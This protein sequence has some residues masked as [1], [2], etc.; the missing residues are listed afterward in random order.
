MNVIITLPSKLIQLIKEG[1]KR[2]EL[3]KKWPKY[4]N[5]QTDNIYICEKGTKY[6]VGYMT[7]EQIIR[8]NNKY[9]ILTDW[10]K[11]IAVSPEWIADYIK[12]AH[13]LVGLFIGE[14]KSFD[15]PLSLDEYFHV[16]KAP[17][18]FVYAS[19]N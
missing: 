3:R 8:T 13:E 14:Y 10:S 7:I 6:V 12:D 4:F 11:D 16:K 17:Q 2:I 1:K 9:G 18:S 5:P 19:N 15:K